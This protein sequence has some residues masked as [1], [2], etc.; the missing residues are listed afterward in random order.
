MLSQAVY[1]DDIFIAHLKADTD[2]FGS[3]PKQDQITVAWLKCAVPRHWK[4]GI[5]CPSEVEHGYTDSRGSTVL[6]HAA[7]DLAKP[8]WWLDQIDGPAALPC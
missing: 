3:V 6:V 4:R 1:C 8:G 7:L 5:C 2:W